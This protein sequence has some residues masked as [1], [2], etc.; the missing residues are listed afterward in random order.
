M[1]E[2]IMSISTWSTY[3]WHFREGG[4]LDFSLD[5]I[6]SRQDTSLESKVL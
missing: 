1:Y 4:G 3:T 6:K 5:K 2:T